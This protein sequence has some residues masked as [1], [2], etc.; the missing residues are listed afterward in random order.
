MLLDI[1][2]NSMALACARVHTHMHTQKQ[3]HVFM[4]DNSGPQNRPR[5]IRSIVYATGGK[6]MQRGKTFFVKIEFGE[7]DKCMIKNKISTFSPHH[8]KIK[9]IF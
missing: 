1:I 5:H 3:T 4:E 9:E 8:I 2:H 7:L 6:N